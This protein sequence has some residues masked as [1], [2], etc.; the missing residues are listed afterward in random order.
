MNPGFRVQDQLNTSEL[1][2][3]YIIG[4]EL[5]LKKTASR[6]WQ[7]DRLNRPWSGYAKKGLLTWGTKPGEVKVRSP[8]VSIY[9]VF[10]HLPFCN[11]IHAFRF[12]P[13]FVAV[14]LG[15]LRITGVIPEMYLNRSCK[16]VYFIDYFVSERVQ[17]CHHRKLLRILHVF[18]GTLSAIYYRFSFRKGLGCYWRNFLPYFKLFWWVL[19]AIYHYKF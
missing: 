5:N 18:W 11:V 6:Q 7:M 15:T 14:S 2:T 13:P 4:Q 8:A 10:K 17:G 9:P 1:T 16:L 12:Y 19:S 3:A